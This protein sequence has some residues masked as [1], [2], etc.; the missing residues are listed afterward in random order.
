[1]ASTQDDVIH[2]FR[3]SAISDDNTYS[4]IEY[5]YTMQAD[6]SDNDLSTKWL[7]DLGA[8]RMMSSHHHWFKH[9]TPLPKPIK[10]V[11]GDNS[12]IPATCYGRILVRMNAG[13]HFQNAVLQDVLYV[14]DLS[15]NLLSVSHFTR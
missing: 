4:G 6:L 11:L 14:P 1:M 15:G 7:I 10:V 12:S 2:L 8:S 5:A 9:F 3:A 13:D